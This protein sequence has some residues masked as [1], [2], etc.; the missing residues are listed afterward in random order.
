[1]HIKPYLD[2]SSLINED[3]LMKAVELIEE[4]EI[5]FVYG[6]GTSYLVARNYVQK[7]NRIG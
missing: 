3:N 1:M 2:T 4:A 7:W 5:V 6:M